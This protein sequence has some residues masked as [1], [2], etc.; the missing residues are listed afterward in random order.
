M[1]ATNLEAV[2]SGSA[3]QAGFLAKYKK[4][5]IAFVLFGMYASFGMSW[6]GVVPM[7]KDLQ[8][9]FGFDKATGSSL[10]SI[11]SLAKSMVPILAGILAARWG[12]TKTL[13]L[14]SLLIVTGIALPFLPFDVWIAMRFLF[15]VGGAIWVTLMGAVTMQVFAPKQRAL[16]NALNGVA[17][18]VGAVLSLQLTLPLIHAMGWQNT[19][20]LYSA[21]S[22]VFMVLL[23]ALGPLPGAQPS[24]NGPSLWESLKSYAG[25]LKLPV[26]WL[27]SFSFS[28]PLALYLVFTYWLPIYYQTAFKFEV[29]ATMQ[30]LSWMNIGS[31]VGSVATGLLL[32]KIGKTKG[33]IALG[34]VLLPV[35]SIAAMLIPDKTLLPIILFIAGIGMFVSVSP[36]IT[37]LQGQ[38]GMSPAMVGM[39][40]GT[41]FSV[42]YV[43]S[44]LAPTLVGMAD[45]NHIPLQ[46]VLIGLCLTTVSPA[47]ALL[48]KEIQSA[49]A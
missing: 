47:L 2:G 24:A 30:L 35:A 20:V 8:A 5:M 15:G 23:A 41:M 36:M 33:F 7:L 14:S 40:L 34:A 37:L 38:K 9:A 10:I 6:T 29:P 3:D 42:T 11:V 19:L 45:H 16:I 31:I 49:E 12:L 22:A 17:V 25:T 1:A 28:G 46:P 43:V 18:T 26:T 39:I 13:R 27:I 4:W 48:L 44:S 21:I 32:Q